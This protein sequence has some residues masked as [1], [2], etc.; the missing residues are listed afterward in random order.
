M[1]ALIFIFL[2]WILPIGLCWQICKDRNRNTNKGI[3]LGVFFGWFAAAGLWLALKTRHPV[4]KK[5][6]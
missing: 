4:T 2:V 1:G 6:L 3:F 5:L